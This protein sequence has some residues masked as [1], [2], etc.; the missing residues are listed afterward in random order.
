[1][2]GVPELLLDVVDARVAAGVPSTARFAEV[3]QTS[4]LTVTFLGDTS[5]VA[6]AR[7]DSYSP[8]LGDT[9]VLLKVG[10]RFVAIGALA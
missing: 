2:T 3:S 10:T 8:T 6:M 7:L 4:P 5:A 1:M 9:A